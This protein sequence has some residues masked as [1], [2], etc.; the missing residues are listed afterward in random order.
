MIPIIKVAIGREMERLE[1]RCQEEIRRGEQE[2]E[3]AKKRVESWRACDQGTKS[4]ALRLMEVLEV[5]CRIYREAFGDEPEPYFT[6]IRKFQAFSK[7]GNAITVEQQMG[8]VRM[9][10]HRGR[11]T[12]SGYMDMNQHA[13]G[14]AWTE[15]IERLK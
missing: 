11:I 8:A 10:A 6:N 2:A 13:E 1:E 12:I 9:E 4:A 15:I 14:Q 3:S 5:G 7:D